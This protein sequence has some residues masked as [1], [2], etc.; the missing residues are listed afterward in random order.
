MPASPS[1][2]EEQIV[3]HRKGCVC[4]RC[5][6]NGNNSGRPAQQ[7][8]SRSEWIR[9]GKPA[10]IESYMAA[11]ER[12]KPAPPKGDVVVLRGS[13]RAAPG[14]V[15]P[16]AELEVPRAEWERLGRPGTTHSYY[17]ALEREKNGPPPPEPDTIIIRGSVK[18]RGG[19]A[20]QLTKEIPRLEWER[21]GRPRTIDRY[22]QALE[23]EKK[24]AG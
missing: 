8:I 7:T 19:D 20:T 3:L 24:T 4:R 18:H 11:L 16:K 14:G 12:D 6:M 5:K 15:A 10:T 17:A 1:S 21:L 23:D 22:Q 9:L 13:N 2:A